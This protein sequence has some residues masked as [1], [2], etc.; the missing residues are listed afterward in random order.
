M[1]RRAMLNARTRSRSYSSSMLARSARVRS[2][3]RARPRARSAASRCLRARTSLRAHG[4]CRYARGESTRPELVRLSVAGAARKGT[5][6]S[7]A[8]RESCSALAI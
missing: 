7:A 5:S 1:S 3:S 4:S 8:S 6:R 2:C